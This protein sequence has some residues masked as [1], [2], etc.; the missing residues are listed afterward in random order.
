MPQSLGLFRRVE[1]F[2]VMPECCRH[3]LSGTLTVSCLI[4]E[5]IVA[6][7]GI[8]LDRLPH[9]LLR[10]N[11]RL[12]V[13]FCVKVINF[14]KNGMYLVRPQLVF[15]LARKQFP[16]EHRLRLCRGL[17]RYYLLCTC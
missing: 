17:C 11:E 14:I 3:I 16:Q 12:V 8:K 6:W 9:K 2:A 1:I 13:E 4:K 7:V 5:P 10:G 15:L